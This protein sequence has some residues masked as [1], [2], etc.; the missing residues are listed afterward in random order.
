MPVRRRRVQA[1]HREVTRRLLADA[2][3]RAFRARGYAQT[4]VDQI[5]EE[6]GA[7]RATFY[8]HFRTKADVLDDLLAEA[9][10]SFEGS[11]AP[12][13]DAL[14]RRDREATL[15]WVREAMKGWSSIEDTM[16][17]IYEAANADT[18]TYQRLF[19]DDLPG[20][21]AMADELVAGGIVADGA[22]G[23][24][25]AIVLYAP[26]LH[27]FRTHLRGE[28]FDHELAARVI[29]D[30]WVDIVSALPARR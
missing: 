26:L 14:Q 9:T 1:A 22:Q 16:R 27:L 12:L 28:A 15:A 13:V 23:G 25:Y 4:T 2:A 21:A 3:K 19:P 30:S 17:P 7:S 10:A 8:L 20:M 11:Y 24:F 29:A 18:Q 6:A 5:A